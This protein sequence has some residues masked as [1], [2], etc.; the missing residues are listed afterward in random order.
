MKMNARL[1]SFIAAAA[2][3]STS[4][5]QFAQLTAI[6]NGPVVADHGDSTGCAWGD[7][8]NDGNL[9]LFVSNF[10]TPFNYL[11]RNNGDG[12]FTRV[13][14]G[15]IAT[16][17]ANSE[18]AAWGDYDNDGFPDLFVAVGLGGNDLL[19]RNNGDGSFTKIVDGPVVQSGGNSRGC[20]WGD[21][22]NDGN[23]DLF[24]ANEQ[25]Q[26]NFLFHNN[27]D[28]TFDRITSGSI[29]NDGG[30]SYGCAWGDYDN[31]GFLDLFVANL[32]QANFLYHN[33]GDGTFVRITSG[34]VATDS[35]VSQGVAWGD[36]DN[37]GLLD[38]FVANRNQKS[39]LYHNE[40]NGVFTSITN[41]PP[42][43]DVGYA[44]SPA[45]TDYDNDG[46]LDLFVVNG[47]PSGPGQNDFLFHNNGDGTFT[48]VTNMNVGNDGAIGDGC[49]W[50]DYNNDGFPDLFVSNLNGQ[51]NLLYRNSGNENNWLTVRCVGRLS[52]RSGI[53]TKVRVNTVTGSQSR[54]QTREISGGSGYG[55]QNAPFACFGLGTATNIE[56]VRL[57]WPSGV[58]QEFHSMGPRQFVT[59]VEPAVTVSPSVLM[60]NSGQSATFTSSVPLQSPLSLRWFHDGAPIPGATN[61]SHSIPS[62]QAKDA[63]IY[64]LEIGQENPSMTIVT[65]PVRLIGPVVLQTN[66]PVILTRPG[67]N[68]TF[69]V[70]FTGA[71]PVQ[72]QWRHGQQ[73]IPSATNATL[74]LTNIQPA[75]D[76]DYSVIA[77]N[78][79]GIVEGLAASLVVLIKP[80]ITF[81]PVSQ[82]VVA[83]GNVVLSVAVAAHPLPVSYRWR[84]GGTVVTNMI[85]HDTNCF[86]AITDVQA[87]PGTN[88]VNYTVA[89]T[90]L[91]G[92]ASLSS[93]AVLTVLSDTD[94]DGLPDEWEAAWGLNVTNPADAVLDSDGDGATNASEYSAGTDPQNPQDYLRLE[95][96]RGSDLCALRFFAVSN[97]NYSVLRRRGFAAGDEWEPFANVPATHTNRT[98]EIMQQPGDDTNQAFFRLRTP[99]SR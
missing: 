86:F 34:R 23:L 37:D 38:L 84:R 16:D 32:N 28:G 54:W 87:N 17:D 76:G 57:E 13:T 72:L 85:V 36:Y 27:G 49:A 83:G 69:Q 90:N 33:N 93:N 26:N 47:P 29:V 55:S 99:W 24:V 56:T 77:S 96:V 1:W 44:W 63:G 4:L 64:F 9:D 5:A 59:M 35:A 43:S 67:S 42:V 25:G 74:T 48:R 78:S 3:G 60:L 92:A 30:A 46:F 45:W 10:G 70:A 50:G 21:Y 18:G 80:T 22:D 58:I 7:Y 12:S 11:Y 61:A 75:D 98:V 51:N 19:Y 65:K 8:D 97:R 95:F 89:I 91:A 66:R 41:G 62:T 2:S 39:F 71:S 79:F 82:R 68:V 14:T 6:T 40:G 53:G 15:T 52:N 73:W 31:D 88:T 81:Q 20:A 94:G